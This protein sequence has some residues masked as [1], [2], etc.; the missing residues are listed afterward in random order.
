MGMRHCYQKKSNGA[1]LRGAPLLTGSACPGSRPPDPPRIPSPRPPRAPLCLRA[2][3]AQPRI[4]SPRSAPPLRP[5]LSRRRR[6]I[7]PRAAG[8]RVTEEER[9]CGNRWAGAR[10]PR[11]S[12]SPFSAPSTAAS[13]RST[14]PCAPSSSTPTSSAPPT[15]TSTAP[16][17][18]LLVAISRRFG[19]SHLGAPASAAR[20]FAAS[21]RQGYGEFPVPWVMIARRSFLQNLARLVRF[22]AS[23]CSLCRSWHVS[24]AQLVGI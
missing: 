13:P 10:R 8:W 16:S 19:A 17:A 9:C 18:P 23:G 15:R 22:G 2:A 21:R 5:K 3:S 6:S 11:T 20:T 12:S 4:P 7:R 14:L 24:C 1:P